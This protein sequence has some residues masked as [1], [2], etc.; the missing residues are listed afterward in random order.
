MLN[1]MVEPETRTEKSGVLTPVHSLE[2]RT[3]K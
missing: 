1:N 2:G 3:D